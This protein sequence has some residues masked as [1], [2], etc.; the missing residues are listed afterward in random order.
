[1]ADHS[2]GFIVIL[3][4]VLIILSIALAYY[5]DI[6]ALVQR[7]L[8]YIYDWIG[9]AHDQET[10]ESEVEFDQFVNGI[11]NDVNNVNNV[12]DNTV[13]IVESLPLCANQSPT[14]TSTALPTYGTM[15][16]KINTNG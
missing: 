14:A 2:D 5:I 13:K 6:C 11:I 15:S 9:C 1:M 4:I 7:A 10:S 16:E 8:Q 12:N 3:C